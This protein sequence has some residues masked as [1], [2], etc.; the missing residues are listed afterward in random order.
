MTRRRALLHCNAG[1]EFGMGHLMRTLA[2]ADA[3]RE[4]GW[5][6]RIIGDLDPAARDVTA[7]LAPGVDV[8]S[9]RGE[10]LHRDLERGAL[11]V[12]VVHLDTYWEVPDLS[13]SAALLSNMQDGAY[14]VR[15]ADL[16]IDANL[17]SE[18]S[19][20]DPQLSA[21]HLA[22]IDAAVVRAQVR[23]QRAGEEPTAGA[24]SVLVVMG[25]TDPQ[26]LTPRVI[27]ALDGIDVPL[28][29][30]VIDP[31]AR[32]EVR[33][34]AA[35]STHRVEVIGFAPDLPALARRHDLAVTAA[36]TSVWDF[37]CM[38]LPMALVC[39]VDNQRIGYRE[40]VG[41]GLAT[42][43][44]E[45]PHDDLE[46]LVAGLR[47]TLGDREELAR[48]GE[49]LRR[50][51]DGLGTWR[52]LSAWEQLITVPPM[53]A[54]RRGAGSRLATI[55][56]AEILF[57]WRN[58]PRTRGSSRSQDPLDWEDHRAWVARTIDD[59]DRRLL[60]V[61]AEGVPVATCR[62]DRH[63]DA[64]WEVSITVAPEQRGRGLASS[65]LAAA[66]EALD[67]ASP[68]RLI[69][70]VHADNGASLKLFQRA[71]YLPQTPPDERGFLTLA[72][73]R[74]AASL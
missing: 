38:G 17:G 4:L 64:D 73:W 70:V 1:L 37:A 25:G 45:P 72:R 74:L 10:E 65:V 13:A 32:P 43:L 3:A 50:S 46:R 9:A 22:G 6:V 21:S 33:S 36:G 18:R 63:G 35:A 67:V 51:V 53:P 68:S 8:R 26:G 44:G 48:E 34:A 57:E 41:R 31:R 61:E 40:V 14:G 58:D 29:V 19:F 23:R 52:I 66:E 15:A 56:D 69:A 28:R 49:R 2:V 59:P 5:H 24:P 39:V 27:A 11:D 71:G 62:W 42:G 54:D 16:A 47:D 20:V 30:T 7:R 60:I 12:D 55:D